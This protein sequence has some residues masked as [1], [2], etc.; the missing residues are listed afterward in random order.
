MFFRCVV[1]WA[2][3]QPRDNQL[4]DNIWSTGRQIIK[5]ENSIMQPWSL[6]LPMSRLETVA[7]HAKRPTLLNR[8]RPTGDV[9]KLVET[10]SRLDHC[11]VVGQNLNARYEHRSMLHWSLASI[12]QTVR[13]TCTRRMLL[14]SGEAE[15]QTRKDTDVGCINC[16]LPH[17]HNLVIHGSILLKLGT[18]GI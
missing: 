7:Y 2:T 17:C 4:G 6:P 12:L 5:L 14:T 8:L 15:Q 18:I 13:P 11:S 16:E 10:M 1:N 9:S 3:N